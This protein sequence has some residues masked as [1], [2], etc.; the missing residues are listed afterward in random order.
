MEIHRGVNV[1]NVTQ[2]NG[3]HFLLL[4][5]FE[6]NI[7]V[8]KNDLINYYFFPVSRFSPCFLPE[9]CST[10]SVSGAVVLGHH[11]NASNKVVRC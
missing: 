4:S 9:L 5:N 1:Q 2:S 10:L 7:F 11:Q 6:L 3:L 8:A